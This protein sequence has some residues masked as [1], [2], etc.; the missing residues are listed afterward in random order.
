MAFARVMSF[1]NG[2]WLKFHQSHIN[3]NRRCMG[4]CIAVTSSSVKLYINR[5]KLSPYFFD[6]KFEIVIVIV[7]LLSI[8][9][10]I[11][12][13]VNHA[14]IYYA[15]S[16]VWHVAV[17]L[18]LWRLREPSGVSEL[19]IIPVSG[20]HSNDSERNSWLAHAYAHL[21]GYG[22]LSTEAAK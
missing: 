11:F 2:H 3:I 14:G 15:E 1:V 4:A 6:A 5:V 10:P 16:I 9:S 7:I 8:T 22:G 13:K 12:Y 20:I 21:W 19:F 17:W 18:W